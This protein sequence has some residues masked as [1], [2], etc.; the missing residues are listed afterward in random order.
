MES[1]SD[2]RTMSQVCKLTPQSGFYSP[3]KKNW[4]K[5]ESGSVKLKKKH[6]YCIT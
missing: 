4:G 2:Y 1:K 6:F 3:T 5:K